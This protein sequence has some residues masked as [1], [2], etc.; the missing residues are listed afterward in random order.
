MYYILM[1]ARMVRD[2]VDWLAFGKEF[3]VPLLMLAALGYF[4]AFHIWPLVTKQLEQTAADRRAE[5]DKFLAALDKRDQV[6]KD[7]TDVITNAMANQSA[8]MGEL[9]EAINR[10]RQSIERD[11]RR[12]RNDP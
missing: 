11:S 4:I 8:R 1:I 3:G 10:I 6:L 9:T 5:L 2:A 12:P 7:H